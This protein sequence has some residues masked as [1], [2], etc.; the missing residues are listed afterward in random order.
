MTYCAAKRHKDEGGKKKSVYLAMNM[1]YQYNRPAYIQ[2]ER[3]YT[4]T[5]RNFVV[6]HK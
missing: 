3:T 2:Q 5:I 1:Q 6:V 4:R